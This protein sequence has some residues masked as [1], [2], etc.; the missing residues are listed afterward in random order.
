LVAAVV[1]AGCL[2][3]VGVT[4]ASA[5]LT[6]HLKAPRHVVVG[7]SAI[8]HATGKIPLA[9]LEFPYW[10]SLDA[11][12]PSATRKCPTDRWAAVQIA[13]STGGAVLVN[14][15]P[16]APNRHG[17]FSIPIGLRPTKPGRVLLCGYTDDGLTNTLAHD[18][19]MLHIKRR[20]HRHAPLVVAT[21]A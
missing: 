14:D 16:E 2:T 1:A 7:R 3:L 5:R 4:P 19:V 20:R 9:D 8:L 21:S 15:Q 17:R 11:I 13:Q 18:G 10:F 6:L 12:P